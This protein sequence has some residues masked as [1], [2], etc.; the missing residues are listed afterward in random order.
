MSTRLLQN[1]VFGSIAAGATSVLAHSINING[2]AILP[3][4]VISNVDG[5]T[6]T[7]DTAQ[8]SITNNNSVAVTPSV[9]LERF[10]STVRQLGGGIDNMTPQPI[11][12]QGSSGGSAGAG[13]RLIASGAV[14]AA[15]GFTANKGF[16]SA[17]LG[18][19]GLYTLVLV[20]PPADYADLAIIVTPKGDGVN[21]GIPTYTT[22]GTP[23]IGVQTFDGTGTLAN[24]AF[25][26][27]VYDLT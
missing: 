2:N 11:I 16:V 23:N 22:P 3:D 1:L 27:A 19:A 5:L 17:T 26:I 18:L 8:V 20:D 10:H 21:P 12:I 6:I 7:V 15:G 14:A 25:S 4:L 9:F 24:M 13:A